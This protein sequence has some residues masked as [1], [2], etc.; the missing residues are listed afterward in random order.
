VCDRADFDWAVA[1]SRRHQLTERCPVL[2]SA[3]HG[4]V[5]MRELAEWVL[6]ARLGLRLQVQL[7]K[8][9]WEPDRRGV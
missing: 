3:V 4:G 8:V 7:H 5:A 2:V 6:D 1:V 9:V